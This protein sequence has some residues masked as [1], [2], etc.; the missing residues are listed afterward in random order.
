MTQAAQEALKILRDGSKSQWYVER[1][2]E[3]EVVGSIL[4]FDLACLVVFAGILQ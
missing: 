2:A 4:G 3:N 1:E